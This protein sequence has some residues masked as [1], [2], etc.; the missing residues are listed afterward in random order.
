MSN[1]DTN[2][3]L[4][5]LGYVSCIVISWLAGASHEANKVYDTHSIVTS[6]NTEKVHLENGLDIQNTGFNVGD[7]LVIIKK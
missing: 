7:T 5:V 6:A 2:M 1:K 4:T 3:F